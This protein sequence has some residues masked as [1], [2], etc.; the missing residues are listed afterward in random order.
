LILF[1]LIPPVIVTISGAQ[2]EAQIRA[3]STKYFSHLSETDLDNFETYYHLMRTG[4][5]MQA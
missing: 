5:P 4:M 3:L 2:A 1:P